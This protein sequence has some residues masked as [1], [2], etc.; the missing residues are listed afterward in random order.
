MCRLEKQGLLD[1]FAAK[2]NFYSVKLVRRFVFKKKPRQSFFPQE[3][4]LPVIIMTEGLDLTFEH[5][6]WADI[7]DAEQSG[8]Q[9]A[10][11]ELMWVY[12]LGVNYGLLCVCLRTVITGIGHCS[13]ARKN[14]SN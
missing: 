3:R 2:E 8:N 12:N 7:V 4:T 13:C 14:L 9:D 11:Q 1:L 10:I 6:D 5:I